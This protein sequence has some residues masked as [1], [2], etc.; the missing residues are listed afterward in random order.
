MNFEARVRLPDEVWAGFPQV[1]IFLSQDGEDLR[2]VVCS[3]GDRYIPS[4][5]VQDQPEVMFIHLPVA[6]ELPCGP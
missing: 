4:G 3:T 1:Q 2:I 5:V 6:G